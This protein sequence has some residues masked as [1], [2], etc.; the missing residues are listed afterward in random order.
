MPSENDKFIDDENANVDM[1]KI[2]NTGMEYIK[3]D[4][5]IKKIEAILEVRKKEFKTLSEATLPDMMQKARMQEFTLMN[6]FKLKV[7]PF[8]IVKLP[9]DNIDE[10]DDWLLA[11][12][13][14]GMVK[15]NLEV[16]LP[17][18]ISKEKV[19]ALKKQIQ[20]VGFESSD[21]KSIH[22]QTLNKWARE[23]DEAGE[24][25]PEEVFEVYKGTRTKI[26]G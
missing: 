15:R 9:K 10:A 2:V 1:A 5:E 17:R 3:L 18:G 13:H 20:E 4:L 16:S 24:I 21:A 19:D 25:I 26:T 14:D 12:G 11:H 7:E 8:I 6:G 23:M 22:Y